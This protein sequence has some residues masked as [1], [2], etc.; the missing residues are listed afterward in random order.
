MYTPVNFNGW[1]YCQFPLG[2]PSLKDRSKI[3]ALNVYY[4]G[5]P[6]GKTVTCCVDEIRAVRSP[7]PLGQPELAIAGRSI[8]F[9]V[10]MNAGD[11]LAFKGMENCRLVRR[12]GEVEEVKPEGS[13]P[14]L[15][16]G[17]NPVVFS[18][19]ESS[20]REF[21]VVVLLEKLYP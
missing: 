11:R 13:A 1:R 9:P 21:R 8:R 10:A 20:P 16:P 15:A 3:A 18:L 17:R 4:N 7:Q 6:A 5:I 12:S 19:P 14:R 2:G